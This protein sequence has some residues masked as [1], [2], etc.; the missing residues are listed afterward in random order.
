MLGSPVI[1]EPGSVHTGS[2]CLGVCAYGCPLCAPGT[3]TTCLAPGC[4]GTIAGRLP[5]CSSALQTCRGCAPHRS[6]RGLHRNQPSGLTKP[7]LWNPLRSGAPNVRKSWMSSWSLAEKTSSWPPPSMKP[8]KSGI[9]H[10]QVWFTPSPAPL[11]TTDPQQQC[12]L[13]LPGIGQ[14]P[15]GN[16]AAAYWPFK[17]KWLRN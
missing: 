9:P 15:Q 5:R 11:P 12:V 13:W 2:G 16:A 4:L 8:P 10:W 1:S 17:P 6:A 7:T 3:R 14:S